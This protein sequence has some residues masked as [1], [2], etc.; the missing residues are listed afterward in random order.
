MVSAVD[1]N[2]NL[3]RDCP[4]ATVDSNSILRDQVDPRNTRSGGRTGNCI[5][6]WHAIYVITPELVEGTHHPHTTPML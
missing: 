1:G 5:G 6:V 2:S 4:R 3:C